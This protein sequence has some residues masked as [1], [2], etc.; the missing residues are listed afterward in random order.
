MTYTIISTDPDSTQLLVPPAQIWVIAA[1]EISIRQGEDSHLLLTYPSYPLTTHDVLISH[2]EG[3]WAIPFVAYPV[4]IS[5]S[6]PTTVGSLRRVAAARVSEETLQTDLSHLAYLMG[7]QDTTFEYRGEFFELKNSPRTPGLVKAYKVIRYG[8]TSVAEQSVRNLADPDLLRSYVFLPINQYEKMT[9]LKTSIPHQRN[10]RWFLGK[11]L[12]SDID[13]LL[14]DSHA[15]QQISATSIPIDASLFT[16]RETGLLCAVDIAGYGTAL[17]YAAEH[18]RSFSDEP[19]VIQ[20]TFRKSITAHFNQILAK[21][22]VMQV[23]LAGDGFIAAFPSRVFEDVKE[24]VSALLG[25]WVE[26]IGRVE[27]LNSA[28]PDR[29]F[30]VGSRMALHYGAYEYGRI[31]GAQSFA[32]AFDGAA[33]IEVARLEQG[34]AAA[35]VAGTRDLEGTGPRLSRRHHY[36]LVSTSLRTVLGEHWEPGQG[37]LT[38]VGEVNLAAKEFAGTGEVWEVTSDRSEDSARSDAGGLPGR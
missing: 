20:Q 11:P 32:A 37:E 8:L 3:Y 7:L 35:I 2:D 10:E 38:E 34:L 29:S 18:M 16:R 25:E 19:D 31:S 9:Q 5:Y 13:Y 12:M 15:R 22:G 27:E 28:I 21:L 6:P 24:T 36:V 1:L 14:A 26:L 17:K 23:Q 33:I 30:R 4:S